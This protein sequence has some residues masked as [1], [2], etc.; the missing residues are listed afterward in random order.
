LRFIR[1]LFDRRLYGR[2]WRLR[3]ITRLLEGR[4]FGLV[5]RLLYRRFVLKLDV[6]G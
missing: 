3:W 1:G 5:G 4:L 2:R 6:I